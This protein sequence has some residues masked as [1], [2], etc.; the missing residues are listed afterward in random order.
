MLH[1]AS[2]CSRAVSEQICSELGENKL[3]DLGFISESSPLYVGSWDA[4]IQECH[5]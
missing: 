4:Q 3:V 5:H 2:G 1:L